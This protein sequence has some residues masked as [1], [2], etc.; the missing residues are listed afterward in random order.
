M[1]IVDSF[2]VRTLA[3]GQKA[4]VKYFSRKL[5]R[6][7]KTSAFFPCPITCQIILI[8][9]ILLWSVFRRNLAETLALK[10]EHLDLEVGGGSSA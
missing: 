7:S 10:T 4:V 3:P 8:P 5:E 1:T 2:E 9:T 6:Q